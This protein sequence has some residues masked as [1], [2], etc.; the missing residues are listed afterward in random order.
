MC[1][2]RHHDGRRSAMPRDQEIAKGMTR[3]GRCHTLT[4]DNLSKMQ[5]VDGR[6]VGSL[7]A[8]VTLI[9]Y[10]NQAGAVSTEKRELK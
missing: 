1:G 7:T 6:I 4:H 8:T 2:T 10:V 9:V 5:E 3:N